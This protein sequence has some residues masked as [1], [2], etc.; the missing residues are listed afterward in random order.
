MRVCDNTILLTKEGAVVNVR[1]SGLGNWWQRTECWSSLNRDLTLRG[2]WFSTETSADPPPAVSTVASA[3][4]QTTTRSTC[5]PRTILALASSGSYVQSCRAQLDTGAM[6]SLI[7]RKLANPLHAKKLK[8]TTVTISGIGGEQYSAAEVE[9][10]LQSLHSSYYIDVRA[11]VVDSIPMCATAAKFQKVGQMNT[12]KNL[13]LADPDVM[14]GADLDLLLGISH[15]NLCSLPN[16]LF[17][18]DKT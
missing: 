1:V 4:S 8:G 14:P 18:S 2:P 9:I 7:T 10:R 15:C 13:R 12:F 3:A 16:A 5:L 11:S 17:S 6:L